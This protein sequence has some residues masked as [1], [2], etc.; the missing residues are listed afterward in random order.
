LSLNRN[1]NAANGVFL[2][3]EKEKRTGRFE[4]TNPGEISP[5]MIYAGWRK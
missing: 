3:T 5:A 4:D 1:L 2:C